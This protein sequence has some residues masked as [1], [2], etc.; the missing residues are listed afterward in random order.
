MKRAYTH[1]IPQLSS[2]EIHHNNPL[3]TARAM[4]WAGFWKRV[5]PGDSFDL[6]NQMVVRVFCANARKH[7]VRVTCRKINGSGY[8]VWRIQ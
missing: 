4:S 8:R 3:P 2:I 6:E 5:R 1:R 7:G